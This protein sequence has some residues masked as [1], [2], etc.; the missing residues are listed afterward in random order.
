MR[1][2]IVDADPSSRAALADVLRLEAEVSLLGAVDA[3]EALVPHL[4]NA[5]AV[6]VVADLASEDPA[7]L[8]GWLRREAPDVA[9]V[10]L[11]PDLHDAR[12]DIPDGAHACLLLAAT[13]RQIVT[14]A[15]GAIPRASDGPATGPLIQQV[16]HA[17][18][19]TAKEREVMRLVERG[20]TNQQ[21]ADQLYLSVSAVKSH[22]SHVFGRLGVGSRDAAVA[23]AR[24][25]G[26]L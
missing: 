15:R 3:P 6:L 24:R 22:L 21:I 13:P 25:Q 18:D 12:D 20:A 10:V 19:L 17:T 26:V 4:A 23:E 8:I 16:P 2:A 1:L 11:S 7:P 14:A 5:E 9:I